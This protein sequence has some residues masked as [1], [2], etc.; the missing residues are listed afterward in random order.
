MLA[1]SKDFT[2][3]VGHQLATSYN[4][5]RD[6]SRIRDLKYI[7]FFFHPFLETIFEKEAASLESLTFAAHSHYNPPHRGDTNFFLSTTF[8]RLQKLKLVRCC[9]GWRSPLLFSPTLTELKIYCEHQPLRPSLCRIR[10][11]LS[12]LRGL[13]TLVLVDVVRTHNTGSTEHLDAA[14]APTA[15]VDIASK[16]SLSELRSLRFSTDTPIDIRDFLAIL[17]T[18]SDTVLHLRF[19]RLDGFRHVWNYWDHTRA[20]PE[21]TLHNIVHT[22]HYFFALSSRQTV[23]PEQG[24]ENGYRS[25]G[26]LSTELLSMDTRPKRPKDFCLVVGNHDRSTSVEAIPQIET[27]TLHRQT[28]R[29]HP[30]EHLPVWDTRFFF[31]LP[32]EALGHSRMVLPVTCRL[33]PLRGVDTV[34]VNSS[35]FSDPELWWLTFGWMEHVTTVVVSGDAVCGFAAALRGKGRPSNHHIYAD[36]NVSGRDVLF[37]ER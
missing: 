25:I 14:S 33:L 4:R 19:K 6:I 37:E 27:P 16:A 36:T 26:I 31:G 18:P 5:L 15:T 10:E 32:F 7:G 12:S 24:R 28:D 35:A 29:F 17:C 2:I 3:S 30:L 9:A 23:E 8:P 13:I 34:F 1:R 11:V 20:P 21:V 22:I